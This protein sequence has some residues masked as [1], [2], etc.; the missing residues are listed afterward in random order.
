M[1]TKENKQVWE[2]AFSFCRGFALPIDAT[3]RWKIQ[4]A[5]VRA[6]VCVYAAAESEAGP[7][8]NGESQFEK[9]SVCHEHE[10][11]RAT[12]HCSATLASADLTV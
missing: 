10:V 8:G 3:S 2:N 11:S 6:V 12:K 9:I 7:S 1:I 4:F 5:A